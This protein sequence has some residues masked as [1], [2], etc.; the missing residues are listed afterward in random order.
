ML[1]SETSR[2]RRRTVRTC[3]PL[4]P[5]RGARTIANT[6]NERGHRTTS[7]GQWSAHQVLRVLSNR[8]YLGE[9][10]FRGITCAGCHPPIIEQTTF[11]EAQR[12]LS[13][14][15]EDHAAKRAASGSDYLLTGLMRCPA[16]GSDMLGTRTRQDPHLPELL[17]L[18]AHPIRQHHLRWPAGRRRRHRACRHRRAGRLLPAPPGPD[19]RRHRR[20]PSL[21]CSRPGC[22]PW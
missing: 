21:T 11:D 1:R 10:T 13:A 4:E 8:I 15:G 16:C 5:R 22:P 7:G 20:R 18:P 19:R 6:L 17:L 9:L 14:R 3:R 2:R 12:L